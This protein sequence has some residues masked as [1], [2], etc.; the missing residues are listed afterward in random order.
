VHCIDVPDPQATIDDIKN[1]F[2][3]KIL[4]VFR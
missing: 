2:E 3:R 1:G 4:E